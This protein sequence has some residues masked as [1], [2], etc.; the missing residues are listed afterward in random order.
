M[1][2]IKFTSKEHE[3]FYTEMIQKSGNSDSYHRAFFYCI[4]ISDTTRKNVG[5]IFDFEQD[6]IKPHGLYEGWQTG[7]TVRLTYLALN[8]WNGYVEPGEER[9]ST[10]YEM[11]D[12]S[13]APY[14]YE[15]IKLRYPDYC[16][17]LP[18]SRTKA[19][20]AERGGR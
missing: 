14:F 4:G 13:F 12:C 17:E 18:M 8:L 3:E 11:F 9:M 20:G 19:D 5:R 6:R 2:G 16:R 10:P 15:A 7:G 1:A